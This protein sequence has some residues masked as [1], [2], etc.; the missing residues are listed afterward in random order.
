M[1]ANLGLATRQHA[2]QP[3][4]GGNTKGRQVHTE[5]MDGHTCITG[6]RGGR[7]AGGLQGGTQPGKLE[8]D[9]S[10]GRIRDLFLFL[11]VFCIF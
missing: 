4:H 6:L 5:L 9:L 10:R 1:Q 2:M 7:E 11:L 8:A 3:E